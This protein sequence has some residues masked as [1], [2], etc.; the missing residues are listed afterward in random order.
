MDEKKRDTQ[1]C[2]AAE[3]FLSLKPCFKSGFP[4]REPDAAAIAY[5]FR[6]PSCSFR[7]THNVLSFREGFVSV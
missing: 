3:T 6:Q 5:P 1:G 4:T 2:T 7:Q